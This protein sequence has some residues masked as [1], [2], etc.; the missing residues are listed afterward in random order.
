M[1][2][3]EKKLRILVTDGGSVNALAIV[4]H[5][6]KQPNFQ[7]FAVAYNSLALA[8][9]SR[10][11]SQFYVVSHPAKNESKFVEEILMLIKEHQIDFF[12]PV[13]FYAHKAAITA[14]A[15]LL[16]HTR[17]CLPG[18]DAFDLATSKLRTAEIAGSLGI[19]VPKTITVKDLSELDR[20]EGLNFPVVI[21]S[22]KEI[23]GRM[24]EY[25]NSRA[26]MLVAFRSLVSKNQL[27]PAD[28]PIIQEYISGKGVG[29]FA[30]YRDGKL[31]SSF[32]HERV[33]EFPVSGGRSVCARSF[34]DE[35]LSRSG[36]MLLDSIAWNGC[37]M[38]EYK[39]TE[40]N[41]YYL[42]EIN[43]KLW[44]SLELAICSGVNFPLLM[45]QDS[46][47]LKISPPETYTENLYFQWCLNGELYHL[48]NRPLSFFSIVKTL[49]FSK[50]DFSISDIKPNLMQGLL[51]PLDLYKFIKSKLSIDKN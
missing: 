44:G 2:N 31:I 37:A 13:G 24:I 49:F 28:Y 32:M 7:I 9:F 45:V 5:L 14:Q 8:K 35:K 40:N 51:I 19:A 39:R 18:R 4:R 50:K 22:Q 23:G 26:E 38:V 46:C 47:G 11:C 42:L 21:K 3:S 29:Y 41:E 1:L 20:I 27:A 36:K 6:G 15:E 30:F 33:R 34:S 43:P 48:A 16:K 10:Y 17:T 25:A 12:M